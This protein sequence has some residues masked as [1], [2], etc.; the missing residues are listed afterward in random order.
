MIRHQAMDLRPSTFGGRNRT[1]AWPGRLR[2]P[3]GVVRRLR[4]GQALIVTKR[5]IPFYFHRIY[6]PKTFDRVH[7][8]ICNDSLQHRDAL[9]TPCDHQYCK[10]CVVSLVEHFTKDESLFPLRCCQSPIPVS[11]VIPFI[12]ATLNRLFLSKH[13]EF[14]VLSKDRIYCVNPTCS[15]FLGSS[16][17]LATSAVQCP[18]CRQSTCPRCK[19]T[20]HG[21]D[22]CAVNTATI[23][24]RAL[25]R[26]L[27]WQT[28]P[29]CH[30]L[31]ELQIGCYHM[32]CRCRTQF[33]YL[34]AVPWK[35]CTCPQW[36]ENRLLET[37]QQRVANELGARG[38]RNTAPAALRLQV[39]ERVRT[40][41]QNHD[42]EQHTWRYRHGG[43]RCEECHFNLPQYLLVRRCL[44]PTFSASTDR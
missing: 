3:F 26:R 12:S 44:F 9:H 14:S 25:A 22:D 41:R 24:L 39:E 28:C 13:T 27:G 36:E 21:E 4:L 34:C 33:C 20:A 11:D 42:C 17:G 32:T 1:P 6:S 16:K 5:A 38:L 43:G 31:V 35:G 30:T 19:Q 40:L 2:R 8:T 23:Q 7:C 10:D 18:R 37:A 29:G 15:T